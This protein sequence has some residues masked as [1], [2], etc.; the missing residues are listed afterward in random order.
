MSTATVK[1]SNA[2][3]QNPF[4]FLRA[5]TREEMDTFEGRSED[6]AILYEKVRNNRI[7]LVYG[8]SGVGKTSLIQCGLANSFQP[9]D[10]Y[11]VLIQRKD[12]INTSLLHTLAGLVPGTDTND[13]SAARLVKALYVE[14]FKPI[15][16]IFDQ[17]EELY[18]NGSEKEIGSFY[19]TIDEIIHTLNTICRIVFI[20]REDFHSRLD[21]FE[22]QVA[23]LFQAG[24]RVNRLK[25][26][27]AVRSVRKTLLHN[28]AL[29]TLSPGLGPVSLLIA[30]KCTVDGMVNSSQLQ[31]LLFMLWRKAPKSSPGVA[32]ISEALIRGVAKGS[33]ELLKE[34]IG[35]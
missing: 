29:V 15:Y 5:Y 1:P 14:N 32:D 13:T 2:V 8:E 24:F 22:K 6:I 25:E 9:S 21:G 27:D 7:T 3:G 33:E 12:D 16:L 31:I 26:E 30:E 20:I 19:E 10:W 35:E 17:L 11:D 34:Y 18:V 28:K 23:P 4:R